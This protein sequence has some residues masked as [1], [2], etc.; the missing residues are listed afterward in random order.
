[1]IPNCVEVA[2]KGIPAI[3]FRNKGNQNNETDFC[4]VSN[5]TEAIHLISCIDRGYPDK[6]TAEQLLSAAEA[7]NPGLWA[8]HCRIAARCAERIAKACSLDS[9][10][11]YILGLLHDIGRRFLV[12]DLGHIYYGYQYMNRLGFHE[13]SRVCLTHSFPNQDLKI[14][15]GKLDIP[16]SEISEVENLLHKIKF[17][18]YD[19]LILLCD[20]LAGS[21]GVLDIEKRMADVK[22]RYGNYPQ[23]QWNKN[24]E[25]KKYFED[26]CG[27]NIYDIVSCR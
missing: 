5:W 6:K 19:K 2:K 27:K 3:V 14:Y 1:M 24:L 17:N 26:C 23:A 8:N 9:E 25:L 15:I 21:D 12:R 13:V 22:R 18:V 11:A 10:K 16:N 7:I 20:A 4:S